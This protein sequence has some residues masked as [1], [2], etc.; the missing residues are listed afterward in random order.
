[1]QPT[2][3]PE[4]HTVGLVVAYSLNYAVKFFAHKKQTT[5]AGINFPTLVLSRLKSHKKGFIRLVECSPISRNEL[6]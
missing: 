6:A 4:R 1:M 3:Y 2:V 5:R